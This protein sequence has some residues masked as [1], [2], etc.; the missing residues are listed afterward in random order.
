M[1]G[2]H[3]NNVLRDIIKQQLLMMNLRVSDAKY[4]VL[5]SYPDWLVILN[6]IKPVMRGLTIKSVP[7]WL[8]SSYCRYIAMLKYNCFLDDVI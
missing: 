8:V 4:N 3:N 1:T 2:I 6:T 5:L 7:T